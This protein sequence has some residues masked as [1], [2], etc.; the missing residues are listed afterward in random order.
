MSWPE[1]IS[2]TLQFEG[3]Y[4]ANPRDRG[5]WTT[6]V[7]GQGE[8]KGT[9]YGIAAHVYPHLDIKNLTKEEAI[10]I[11]R[12]DY[13]PKVAGDS[14]P[15]GVNLVAWDICVNSGSSRATAIQGKALGTAVR[16]ATGLATLAQRTP[17][18]PGQVKKM[19]ALRASFYRSLSSFDTFGKGW[20]R[21]NAACEVKGVSMALRAENKTPEEIKK[22]L[23]EEA[24]KAD[25]AK[26]GNATGG[27]V[28]GGGAAV[29]STTSTW[30][31][32]WWTLFEFALL[33][34]L[35]IVALYFVRKTLWHNE[36]VKAYVEAVRTFIRS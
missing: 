27:T 33:L 2:F 30:D 35:M 5:N 8:L 14:Q 21:R 24:K 26:K 10:A 3:G 16:S 23:G 25:V 20:L 28:T 1:C 6:G 18:K 17:D 22:R 12:R 15:E 36:R 29:E 9:K 11:Y 7:I 19:C 32:S 13:W 34:A 4:D 31:F